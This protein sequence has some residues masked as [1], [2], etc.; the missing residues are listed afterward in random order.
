MVDGIAVS[1][2]I[3]K[4]FPSVTLSTKKI[5]ACEA[6]VFFKWNISEQFIAH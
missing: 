1:R 6:T 2:S 4:T 5:Y 3:S